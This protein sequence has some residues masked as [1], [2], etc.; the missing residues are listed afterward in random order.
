MGVSS[1][2]DQTIGGVHTSVQGGWRLRR[3]KDVAAAQDTFSMATQLTEQQG[4]LL[5]EL[6]AASDLVRTTLG[7]QAM[8]RLDVPSTAFYY[9]YPT[10]RSPTTARKLFIRS[11]AKTANRTIRWATPCHGSTAECDEIG[12]TRDMGIHE[13]STMAQ[14]SDAGND[15]CNLDRRDRSGASL[16][17]ARRRVLV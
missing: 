5:L 12:V 1:G 16:G 9:G 7:P 14:S 15:I 11:R 3:D 13:P 10:N 2:T 8:G 17:C 6:R 4:A